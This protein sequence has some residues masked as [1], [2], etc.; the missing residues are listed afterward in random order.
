MNFLEVWRFGFPPIW[1]GSDLSDYRTADG[2]YDRYP[3]S[4]LP[5]TPDDEFNGDFQWL[6]SQP[7]PMDYDRRFQE[8]WTNYDALEKWKAEAPDRKSS[9]LCEAVD[10][11]I[12]IPDAFF[13]FMDDIDL[14][15]RLRSPTDC[16]FD[17]PATVIP[18]PT[19]HCG[20][21]I[22]FWSDSQHCCM[23]YLYI[24]PQQNC[25]VVASGA[26]L[27]E[28]HDDAFWQ[29][30]REQI[31]YCA[32]SFESFIWRLWIENE[33]WFRLVERDQPLT[34]EMKQY[35]HFYEMGN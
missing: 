33:I 13:N 26:F 23:W 4:S 1:V 9:L 27:E 22:H 16:Y 14:V 32:P 19:A 29:N 6:L 30:E 25:V 11:N 15:A 12:K 28:P 8:F 3:L 5:P 34:S 35:L 2:T 20:H 18:Y 31:V 10:R 17:Y 21:F 7:S 24:D